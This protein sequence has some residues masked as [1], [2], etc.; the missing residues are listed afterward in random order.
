MG[1]DTP[2]MEVPDLGAYTAIESLQ[3][4]AVELTGEITAE[5]TADSQGPDEDTGFEGGYY[6]AFID[7]FDEIAKTLDQSAEKDKLVWIS[8]QMLTEEWQQY[9]IE[10]GLTLEELQAHL[11][12]LYDEEVAPMSYEALLNVALVLEILDNYANETG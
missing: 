2:D 3:T 11:S 10:N 12:S 4:I 8:Q 1:V 7:V 6:H 5:I 9:R